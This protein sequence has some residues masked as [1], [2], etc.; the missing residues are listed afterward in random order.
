MAILYTTQSSVHV[1]KNSNFTC[2]VHLIYKLLVLILYNFIIIEFYVCIFLYT[3]MYRNIYVKI[4]EPNNR[5][6][7]HYKLLYEK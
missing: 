3:H 7:S 6:C 5:C 1:E 2:I 4:N